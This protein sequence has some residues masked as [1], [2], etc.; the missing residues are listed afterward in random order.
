MRALLA[1][2]AAVLIASPALAQLPNPK[3]MSGQ[4]LPD[5]DWPNGTATVPVIRGNFDKNLAGQSVEFAINGTK[6]AVTT[7]SEGRAEVAGL[8]AGTKLRARVTVDGELLESQDAVVGTQ[9]GLRI[10]LVATD[11]E[12]EALANAPPTKGIVVFGPESRIIVQMNHDQLNIYYMMQIV[13]SARTPVEIGGPMVF[14]LPREA[15]GATVLEGSTPMATA[16]GPRIT[17]TGPFPPGNTVVE[18]A[19]ELPYR[20]PVAR[21]QQVW[22]AALPQLAVFVQQ[23]GGLSLSSPQVTKTQEFSDDGQVVILG[24]GPGL[25]A[26]QS[27]SLEIAGMPHRSEWPRRIALALAGLLVAAG[28]V[29]VFTAPQRRAA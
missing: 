21:M 20:G 8:A 18:V 25:G 7:N 28:F 3:Q 16:N 5:P 29:G 9:G 2:C 27:L 17:V 6:R 26:G 12:A 1:L 13:N 22:P 23:I 14:N 15:R 19:Y 24:T 10:I 4:V 11:P